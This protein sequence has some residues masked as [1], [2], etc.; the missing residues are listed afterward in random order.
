MN[1]DEKIVSECLEKLAK[2]EMQ[3]EQAYNIFSQFIITTLKENNCELNILNINRLCYLMY[4]KNFEKKREKLIYSNR[5]KESESEIG[6]HIKLERNLEKKEAI[7]CGMAIF[8][9][10]MKE[11]DNYEISKKGAK[12]LNK[13]LESLG[14]FQTGPFNVE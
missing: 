5:L 8:C 3:K 10:Y 6:M 7:C 13:Y 14:Y 2:N 11:A 1:F 12:I 4:L 9:H